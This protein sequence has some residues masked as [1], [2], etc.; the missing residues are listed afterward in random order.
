V[1]PAGEL[2]A[3]DRRNGRVVVFD[4][5]GTP[6]NT[7]SLPMD[8]YDIG[9]RHG[10]L[11]VT[12]VPH[13][14]VRMGPP[15]HVLSSSGAVVDSLGSDRGAFHVARHYEGTRRIAVGADGTVAL[16]RPWSYEIDVFPRV[17]DPYVIKRVVSWFSAWDSAYASP[18]AAVSTLWIDAGNVLWVVLGHS[19][20]PFEG[21]LTDLVESVE[22]V[23]RTW[24]GVVEAFDLRS[25]Q[26]L[27]TV[28]LD[29]PVS[30]TGGY[31]IRRSQDENGLFRLHVNRPRVIIPSNG[32]R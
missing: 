27:A 5:G 29:D 23:N 19:V 7:I 16:A 8:V 30:I 13:R 31:I 12:S 22:A 18:P 2:Y 4:S 3:L 20:Q 11:L 32:R 24:D 21:S 10:E 17:G 14:G 9:I 6:V 1:S 15:L 28:R 25:R 26:H